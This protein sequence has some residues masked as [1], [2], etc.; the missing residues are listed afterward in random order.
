MTELDRL[1]IAEILD[2]I[3]AHEEWSQELWEQFDE[4]LRGV[5]VDDLI[6]YA[7]EELIHYSGEFNSMNLLGLR[8]RPDKIQVDAYK[9]EFRQICLAIRSGTSWKEYK[10]INNIYEAADISSGIKNL[11]RRFMP[12]SK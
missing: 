11:V 3:A 7:Y 1:R 6:A 10:R 9:T 12:S 4:R 5:S 8:T 2:A